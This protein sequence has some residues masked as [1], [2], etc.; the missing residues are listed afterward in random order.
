MALLLRCTVY[1]LLFSDG[2]LDIIPLDSISNSSGI[3]VWRALYRHGGSAKIYDGPGG[4][5]RRA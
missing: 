2:Y 3:A 5:C 4:M 1:R